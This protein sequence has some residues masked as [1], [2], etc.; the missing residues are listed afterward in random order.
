MT[1][2]I[3]GCV[4]GWIACVLWKFLI[5]PVYRNARKAQKKGRP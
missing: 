4:A 5:V 2:F 3:F 1:E